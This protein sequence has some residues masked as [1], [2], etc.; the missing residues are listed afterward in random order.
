M[1]THQFNSCVNNLTNFF[2]N[3]LRF[4]FNVCPIIRSYLDL[5]QYTLKL[6]TGKLILVSYEFI[7]FVMNNAFTNYIV[8]IHNFVLLVTAAVYHYPTL[9]FILY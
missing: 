4:N 1:Y 6:N 9:D 5:V 3:N 7:S 2:F 8:S